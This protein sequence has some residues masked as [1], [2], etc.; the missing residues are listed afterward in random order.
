MA[1]YRG[2]GTSTLDLPGFP[3]GTFGG[4]DWVLAWEDLAGGGDRDYRDFI[5]AVSDVE[6]VPEPLTI[7]GTGLALGFGGLFKK[8]QSKKQ[9]QKA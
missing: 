6:P 5:V 3:P 8:Q 4:D 7:L 9:G 1:S 2:D